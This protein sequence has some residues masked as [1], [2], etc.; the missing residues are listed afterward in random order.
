MKKRLI[1]V[2]VAGSLM[3]TG[4][5]GCGADTSDKTASGGNTSGETTVS[6]T[7]DGG[8]ELSEKATGETVANGELK[9]LNIGVGGTDGAWSMELGNLAY[10]KGYLE[11]ELN[12]AGYTANV[13]AFQ[14]AGPEINEALASGALNAAVYG[15]FP[16]F[17]SKSNGIDTT[18]VATTNK[19]QQYGVIAVGDIKGAKD[20][21][22]KKVIVPTGTVAQYYWEHY[23]EATGID[24]SKIELIN[25]TDATSLL[26]TGEADAY[27]MT[28][29]VLEYFQ[30]LGLGAILEDSVGIEGATTTYVFTVATSVLKEDPEVGVAINKALIRAYHD[31]IENPQE[32][33]EAVASDSIGAA[34]YEPAYAFDTTFGNLS[35]E[36]TDADISYYTE[37]QKW[38]ID[39]GLIYSEIDVESFF[40]GSYYTQAAGEIE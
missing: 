16:A 24:A 36:I 5:V 30:Q 21:E 11:E 28:L 31:A 18:V 26:A 33:Y 32:L 2:L 3:I 22:G 19:T 39:N 1:T 17:T 34:C 14:G 6:E 12:T 7:T 23:V 15:D 35:P 40:D 8:T 38:L 37:L 20:L 4:L 25:T 10:E 13:V 29:P 9:T 27:A